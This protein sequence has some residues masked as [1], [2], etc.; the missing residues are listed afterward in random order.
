MKFNTGP[1]RKE[2][3]TKES[4]PVS[5]S[6]PPAG[7]HRE[8]SVSGN[9]CWRLDS[10]SPASTLFPVWSRRTVTPAWHSPCEEWRRVFSLANGRRYLKVCNGRRIPKG[11]VLLWENSNM[12]SL[13]EP[14]LDKTS[15]RLPVQ[16]VCWWVSCRPRRERP[17]WSIRDSCTPSFLT[18]SKQLCFLSQ[19]TW[20]PPEKN[21][22]LWVLIL[23]MTNFTYEWKQISNAISYFFLQTVYCLSYGWHIRYI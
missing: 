15:P 1:H 5:V 11:G 2:S 18:H 19:I 4:L 21:I 22:K 23:M 10:G 3:L 6:T 13:M 14:R 7:L 17:S 16:L 9:G 12:A 20:K 8:W